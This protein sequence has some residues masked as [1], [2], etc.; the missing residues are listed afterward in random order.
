[1]SFNIFNS[2]YFQQKETLQLPIEQSPQKDHLEIYNN[3][4][5][6]LS[7]FNIEDEFFAGMSTGGPHYHDQQIIQSS[8]QK[9]QNPILPTRNQQIS[10][11]GFK[12][13]YQQQIPH[14]NNQVLNKL[15]GTKR[16]KV[17]PQLQNEQI[18]LQFEQ[19]YEATNNFN[20]KKQFQS[21]A[22]MAS[23]QGYINN[24]PNLQHILNESITSNSSIDPEFYS[25]KHKQQFSSIPKQQNNR[26]CTGGPVSS[27]HSSMRGEAQNSSQAANYY[28]N[29]IDTSQSMDHDPYGSSFIDESG[30][31]FNKVKKR[32]QNKESAVRSRLKKKAY[33]ESVETQLNSAQMENNKLKLDN[34]ALRAENQVLR[35]YLD[36]FE[37]IF[38]KK[39]QIGAQQSSTASNANSIKDFSHSTKGGFT[40]QMYS[41]P[42]SRQGGL[43]DDEIY[44]GKAQ[45]YPFNIRK[46]GMMRQNLNSA[47]NTNTDEIYSQM[48]ADN[49]VPR[50]IH[51]Q[52]V[53][54]KDPN[55]EVS[56]V[57]ER[58]G[59]ESTG[60]N[61]PGK[62]GM[63]TIALVMCVCCF[64]SFFTPGGQDSQMGTQARYNG[65]GRNIMGY[66]KQQQQ[67]E[68]LNTQQVQMDQGT[69]YQ[70]QQQYNSSGGTVEAV[71]QFTIICWSNFLK[72]IFLVFFAIL[73][74]T[75]PL[76]DIKQWAARKAWLRKIFSLN[77]LPLHA[78]K[79]IKNL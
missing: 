49:E 38:R 7:D 68:Q 53:L 55:A 14:Q 77:D 48:S 64:S 59:T 6:F 72:V 44:N 60:S 27:H 18:Q 1:M 28:Q 34:A 13:N 12:Q 35:Q 9:N 36:Y 66:N 51:T 33:Y 58:K 22:M 79:N 11:K 61:S 70:Q 69:L 21:Q 52:A 23:G 8:D 24:F 3:E 5:S 2:S 16:R 54:K 74:L 47:L 41:G 31:Q 39:N 50:G 19:A 37:D 75:F 78:N 71:Y 29:Q 45:L 65:L 76:D 30:E 62:F 17:A 63:F 32:M 43:S 15:V 56:F 10:Q 20:L 40:P 26:G 73:I 57:L 67:D 25:N 4:R 46:R 42:S